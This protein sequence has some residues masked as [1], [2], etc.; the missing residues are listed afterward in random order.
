MV[1]AAEEWAWADASAEALAARAHW[2]SGWLYQ[3]GQIREAAEEAEAGALL[4]QM[5][6]GKMRLMVRA[7]SCL[8]EVREIERATRVAGELRE[9][10]T[11]RRL[12]RMEAYAEWLPRAVANRTRTAGG[13]DEELVTAVGE[14]GAPDI[15]SLVW[16]TEAVI[17]WWRGEAARGAE[18]AGMADRAFTDAGAVVPAVWARAVR[19]ACSPNAGEA[20][21]CATA[22]VATGRPDVIWEVLGLLRVSAGLSDAWGE[23]ARE[24]LSRRIVLGY[25]DWRRGALCPDEVEQMFPILT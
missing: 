6:A 10:A 20:E 15:A 11:A 12:P 21:A 2:V 19:I 5:L 14:I 16:V 1:R 17:A 25:D 8:L 4:P 13:V 24:A 3:T 18:L 9:I 23:A 7:M 22:A